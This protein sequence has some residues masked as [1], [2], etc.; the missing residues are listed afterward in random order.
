MAHKILLVDDS[1]TVR[2]QVAVALTQAGFLAVE[3]GDGQEALDLLAKNTDVK[4]IICDV[5]MPRMSGLEFLAAMKQA[6][7]VGNPPVV[8]LTTEGKHDVIES[9]KSLGA[10]GWIVKPFKADHLI[11]AAKKLTGT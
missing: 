8:M 9:A 10:R 2:Q 5:N 1:K 3:A 11:A 4:L 6:G 7:K